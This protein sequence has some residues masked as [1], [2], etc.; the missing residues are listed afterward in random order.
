MKAEP[1]VVEAVLVPSADG[2]AW[3]AAPV[4]D[5]R[6]KTDRT[7]DDL[8]EERLVR[9]HL[10]ELLKD[11]EFLA[12]LIQQAHAI[13]TGIGIQRRGG[14]RKLGAWF[15]EIELPQ[16]VH[17]LGARPYDRGN[18]EHIAEEQVAL[19]REKTVEGDVVVEMLIRH[20]KFG[21]G[22]CRRRE[23]P[24]R[25]VSWLHLNPFASRRRLPADDQLQG[26]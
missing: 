17:H 8:L 9:R 25:D 24:T 20:A 22:R 2:P 15:D 1:L 26:M 19:L 11:A 14:D 6:G 4:K 12:L 5:D 13:L 7:T 23:G 16:D 18:V 3:R 21:S 10:D